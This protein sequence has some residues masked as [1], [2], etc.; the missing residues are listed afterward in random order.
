MR[1]SLS[2][3]LFRVLD[4]S[5]FGPI[6]THLVNFVDFWTPFFSFLPFFGLGHT[7][8]S[9]MKVEDVL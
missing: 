4:F 2:K 9:Q 7:V 3:C 1:G 5:L 6:F 8:Y